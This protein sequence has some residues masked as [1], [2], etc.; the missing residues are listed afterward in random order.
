[1]ETMGLQLATHQIALVNELNNRNS[2]I[3]LSTYL[4]QPTNMTSMKTTLTSLH[5][6]VNCSA[7]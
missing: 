6:Q 4:V 3:L 1:M 5:N 2:K 7:S